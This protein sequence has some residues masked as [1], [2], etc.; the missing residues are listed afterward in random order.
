MSWMTRAAVVY[1]EV[2][3]KGD[4][5]VADWFMM[6]SPLPSFLI[7]LVYMII[8]KVGPLFMANRKPLEIRNVML[9]YNI[10]MVLLSAYILEEFMVSGWFA[11]YSIS[12]QPVDYS[13]SPQAMRMARVCWWFYFSKFIELLDTIF[14][15]VRKKFNQISF[16][17]VFHHGIMP[18]SWW[19]G[20]KFV[21]GGFGT[22]HAM[23]NSFIHL[24]MYTYY[25]LSAAGPQF[26]KYL[27]WKRYMTSMQITQFIFVVIHASQLLFI[28]CNYPKV[29]AYWIA[30]YALIFLVLFSDY[31]NK[32][33]RMKSQKSGQHQKHKISN[34]MK[35]DCKT[36]GTSNNNGFQKKTE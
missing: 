18:V 2:M 9:V 24:L 4:P 22:F 10:S 36:N 29:F 13:L 30:L 11:G 7:C 15:I 32:T 23:L 8:T 34:N 14:F 17:H 12:C 33:Y 20:V 19:F 26:R 1:D 25:G 5:R 3:Q 35:T 28:P 6:S 16:L 27:W 21:P 31:F